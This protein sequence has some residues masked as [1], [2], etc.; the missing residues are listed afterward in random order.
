[1]T[2]TH[3][4]TTQRVDRKALSH[5]TAKAKR[6]VYLPPSVLLHISLKPSSF[7]F[8]FFKLSPWQPKTAA[9]TARS[10]ANAYAKSAPAS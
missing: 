3:S 7:F 9:T 6:E 1:M 8:F 10:A 4:L 2:Y 5:H